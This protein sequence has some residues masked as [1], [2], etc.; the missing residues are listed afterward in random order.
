ML[1]RAGGLYVVEEVS[2]YEIEIPATAYHPEL[3]EL[4]VLIDAEVGYE[5]EWP[6]LV[7]VDGDDDVRV[8]IKCVTSNFDDLTVLAYELLAEEEQAAREFEAEMAWEA[9][10]ER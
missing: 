1:I 8:S 2:M 5:V 4:D 6:D 7:R 9:K 3:G 10:H